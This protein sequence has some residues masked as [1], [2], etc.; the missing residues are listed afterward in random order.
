MNRLTRPVTAGRAGTVILLSSLGAGCAADPGP[1]DAPLAPVIDD[2]VVAPAAVNVLSAIV[3]VS[4]QNTDSALVRFG[5]V[6][7]GAIDSV[8]PAVPVQN[9]S[10]SIPVLGLQ[11]STEYAFQVTA[12]GD[13]GTATGNLVHFTTAALPA[14]LPSYATAGSQ[15]AP[16]FV[17]FAANGYGVAI[18][19]TGRVV[20]Y[21]RLADPA[22]LNFQPQP[23]GRYYTRPT[24]PVAPVPW[25]EIDPLGNV[26][27]TL[28][29]ARGLIARFHDIIAL[30]DGS[31]WI[32]CD[33]SRVMDLTT[34]GGQADARVTGTVVQ[35]IG[36]DQQPL[37][38]WS[39]FDHFSIEDLDPA[40]RAGPTVNFTHG[41][42]ID[43]DR[44][45]NLLISFRSL[46][47]I[48]SVDTHRGFVLWRMGGRAN[49]F[50]FTDMPPFR[51]QHGLRVGANGSL[52]LLDNLGDPAGSQAE[53]MQVDEVGYTVHLGA[54][55]APAPPT[56]A[57]LGGTTQPLP[58]GALLVAFG[59]GNRVQ[60]FDANGAI[61]WEI[62]GN[63]GYVFRA[64]RIRSLYNPGYGLTR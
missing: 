43:L 42:A 3:N 19:N 21:V 30:P 12:F 52:V 62:Q 14:D 5:T 6:A 61:V 64:T 36:P 41:N 58:G 23:T 11:P 35:H 15:P 50:T 33:E 27:R 59:N 44:N 37:F 29:C 18:D 46:S 60:E 32:M 7:S 16:G 45:G 48:T 22:T 40:D 53:R 25:Q 28:G 55:A 9:G 4:A 17:V 63:S 47:E 10:A 34:F 24:T 20:W 1:L 38:E 51:S 26:T 13:G 8:A 49:Q 56:V 31:F 39:A 2:V 54:T 57:Q